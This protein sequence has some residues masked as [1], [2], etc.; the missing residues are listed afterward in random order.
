MEVKG[1]DTLS[2]DGLGNLVLKKGES[3]F[4]FQ[5][6]GM[7]QENQG[8]RT[9]ISGEYV[10][11]DNAH[12]GFRIH[13]YDPNKPL[14][15][16]PVLLYA[17]Y[18][19][20]SD[21]DQATSIAVDNSGNTYV[22]GYSYSLDFPLATYSGLA[23]GNEHAFVAKLDPTGSNVSYVDFIGGDCNDQSLGVAVD[24]SNSAYA[25][26]YTCSDNFPLQNPYQTNFNVLDAF[27][28][29]ISPDG[30]SLIY[31]TYLGGSKPTFAFA[32]AVDTNDEPYV[33]GLTYSYDFPLQN[34]Y[35]SS[36]APNGGNVS[37]YYGFLTK[38]TS[39]GS[40]LVFSTYFAGSSNTL[41][42]CGVN[43]C[44]PAPV[45]Q[46]TGLALD[47]SGNAY[48]VGETNTYDFPTTSGAYQT[49]NPTRTTHLSVLLVSLAGPEAWIIRRIL[50]D[51]PFRAAR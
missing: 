10:I 30:A 26:G 22:S 31:S 41:Q 18:L 7:Y 39:T 1:V 38:F 11:K 34:A 3:A 25:A 36:V 35:Q 8:T 5:T 47:V 40:S 16:D 51:P 46:V 29:K 37:G 45:S 14:V 15:I 24:S 13:G 32:V 9:P 12:I 33:A 28:T 4:S 50:L 42:P 27:L 20:G 17:S 23:P 19:G 43:P 6:P 48:L 44:W 2:L 21:D 49:T